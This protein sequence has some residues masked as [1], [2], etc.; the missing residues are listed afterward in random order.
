[1]KPMKN[2]Q[3]EEQGELYQTRLSTLLDQPSGRWITVRATIHSKKPWLESL[4]SNRDSRDLRNL[5]IEALSALLFG[6]RQ[7]FW[8]IRFAGT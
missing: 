2:A 5:V 7:D 1:M 8:K 3:G 6:L 4:K